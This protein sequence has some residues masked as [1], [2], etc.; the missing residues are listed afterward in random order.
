MKNTIPLRTKG[1]CGSEVRTRDLQP[2]RLASYRCSIP[3]LMS[4]DALNGRSQ[5]KLFLRKMKD[6]NLRYLSVCLVSSE[7]LSATQPIFLFVAGEGIEPPTSG[8]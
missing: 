2:M 6:S 5:C 1:S 7:V 8:L 4:A 3:L